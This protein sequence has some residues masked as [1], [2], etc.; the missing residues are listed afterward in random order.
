MAWAEKIN[1]MR[2]I[3]GII[4]AVFDWALVM[5]VAVALGTVIAILISWTVEWLI[6]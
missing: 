5:A 4:V 6:L 1:G 3:V 2:R